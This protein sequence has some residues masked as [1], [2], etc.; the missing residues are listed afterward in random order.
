[1]S[2]YDLWQKF[3]LKFIDQ[4]RKEDPDL[5]IS[6]FYI[7]AYKSF[8]N[9]KWTQHL[10]PNKFNFTIDEYRE[11]GLDDGPDLTRLPRTRY[12]HF[13]SKSKSTTRKQQNNRYQR[14]VQEQMKK[15]NIGFKEIAEIWRT[16]TEEEKKAYD[17]Q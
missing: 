12:A 7:E 14:F 4:K 16:L 6:D 17:N 8:L 3:L 1:M 11:I 10:E 5:T 2:E 9:E 15:N 13:S